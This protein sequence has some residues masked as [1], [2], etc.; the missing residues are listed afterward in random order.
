VNF[1]ALVE[2][3]LRG[4]WTALASLVPLVVV[5]A[6]VEFWASVVRSRVPARR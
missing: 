5:A 2:M 4:L 3:S 6:L 1:D